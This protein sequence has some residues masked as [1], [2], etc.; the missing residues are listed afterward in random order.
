MPIKPQS[1]R[2]GVTVKFNDE[3]V[4]K[5]TVITASELWTPNQD[6]LF[7]K[8]LK[9]G[10][11]VKINGIKVEIIAAMQILN[12]KNEKEVTAPKIDPLARF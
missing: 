5:Q 1:I 6:I 8:L 10:G 7:K 3:I 2:K 4:D 11:A 9:Q 12:S